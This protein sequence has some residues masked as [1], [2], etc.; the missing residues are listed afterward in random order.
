MKCF[1]GVACFASDVVGEKH[2]LQEDDLEKIACQKGASS[3]EMAVERQPRLQQIGK[4]ATSAMSLLRSSS[5][6]PNPLA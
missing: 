3:D 6:D 5:S 4:D 1:E 2:K